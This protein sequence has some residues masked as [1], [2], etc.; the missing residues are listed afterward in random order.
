MTASL[1]A[2]RREAIAGYLAQQGET[3]TE[4]PGPPEIEALPRYHRLESP[5]PIEV[6]REELGRGGKVLWVCNTVA[7]AMD[8]VDGLAEWEPTV[9]HSRFRYED[10]VTRHAEAI[11]AFEAGRSQPALAVCTQVAEMSLDLSATLLVTDLAPVPAMIQRLG[12]LNRWALP[13]GAGD[14]SPP[15]QPFLVVEPTGKDGS[16]ATAP[17]DADDFGN[18]PAM[19]RR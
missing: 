8:T 10:R 9:Y 3:L 2:V 15:T 16:P 13:P 19:S 1:P 4:V 6:V 11:S 17:Y 18:W 7:R 5:R 14:P 12:R